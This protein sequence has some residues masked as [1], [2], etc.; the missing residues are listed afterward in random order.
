[1][2]DLRFPVYA[3]VVFIFKLLNVSRNEYRE[4]C[5]RLFLCPLLVSIEFEVA[6]AEAALC[7]NRERGYWPRHCTRTCRIDIVDL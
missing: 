3:L 5:A 2:S 7:A 4:M 1:M 6:E